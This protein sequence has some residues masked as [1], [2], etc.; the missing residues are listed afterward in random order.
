MNVA[1]SI[2][3]L[4][5]LGIA[6]FA[7]FGV[8]SMGHGGEHAGWCPVAI[9]TGDCPA[10]ANAL[11]TAVLHLEGLRGFL[12]ATAA[13]AS[14]GSLLTLI[15]LLAV[16]AAFIRSPLDRGPAARLRVLSYAARE[17]RSRREA[18]LIRWLAIHENSPAFA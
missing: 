12:T 15:V 3:M 13:D 9:P 11:A 17:P 4:T 1:S 8:A 18:H 10:T 6:S 7:M 14:L 2:L 16:L 5:A